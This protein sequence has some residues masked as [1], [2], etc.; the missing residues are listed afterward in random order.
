MA[1]WA[2]K[3]DLEANDPSGKPE[4]V[5]AIVKATDVPVAVST[6]TSSAQD[7]TLNGL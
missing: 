6:V 7:T 5:N 1:P 3:I 4:A 2:A